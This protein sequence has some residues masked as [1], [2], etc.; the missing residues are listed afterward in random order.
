[1]KNKIRTIY[2]VVYGCEPDQGGEHEVGWKMANELTDK[3]NLVV[4]TRK[5]N[6]KLIE[7]AN[8]NN[9]DFRYIENDMFLRFKPR[10][11]FSYMYYLF[12]QLSVFYYLKNIVRK[13]DIVHY[14]TFGNLH[15]PHFLFLL[16]SKLIIGPMGGGSV[17]DA[18]LMKHPP[19]KEK[20]KQYVHNFVNW[21]VKINPMYHLLFLKTDKIILRTEETLNIVPK[22]YHNKCSVFLETGVNSQKMSIVPKNRKL[23]KI[24][25]TGKIINRKNIDQVIEVFMKLVD[26]TNDSLE[27]LIV[28]DGPLKSS[29]EKQY[30]SIKG[31]NF[32][33]KIP[34]QKVESLLQEADLFL[35]CSIKE[36]GS[37]SLFEAAMNNIPIACYNV[38]GMTEFPRKDSSIKIHLTHNIDDNIQ[39][40]SE[41]ITSSFEEEKI[42]ELCTNAINDLKEN[43]DW[44]EMAKRYIEIY[45]EK[46][47]NAREY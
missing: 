23:R 19:F 22:Y 38:S 20:L 15:L 43:Y 7:Q 27:L 18:S 37:H 1:M 33:G 29:L 21:T 45:L 36:G 16:R 14:L 24:I 30:A 32:L 26:S 17:M 40:L 39:R 44:Q 25:T 6:K 4:I 35:F 12:W 28:G 34:H 31:V 42:D 5:S 8:E 3:C 13:E 9:I 41:K 2:L 11:R 10:G 46:E 47:I